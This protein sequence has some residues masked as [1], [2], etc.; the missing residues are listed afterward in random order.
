ML[1]SNWCRGDAETT[2]EVT[3]P[4]EGGSIDVLPPGRPSCMDRSI[5]AS[6][7]M[8]AFSSLPGAERNSARTIAVQYAPHQMAADDGAVWIVGQDRLVRLDPEGRLVWA[9]DLGHADGALIGG[10]HDVAIG[11]GAVWVTCACTSE[12]DPRFGA[13]SGGVVRIDPR[14]NRVTAVAIFTDQTPGQVLASNGAVWFTT[15]QGV[16]RVSVDD[17]KTE[18]TIRLATDY[19]AAGK[20]RIWAVTG[21]K[22]GPFLAKI[23]STSNKVVAK[24]QL[25]EATSGV[26]EAF[27]SVWVT[28]RKSGGLLKIDPYTGEAKNVELPTASA[29]AIAFGE[30]SIWVT[31]FAD[32]TLLRIDPKTERV[33]GTYDA[34]IDP[35]DVA[36]GGGA[37]WV[38]SYSDSTV[39]RIP[40]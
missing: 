4:D 10:G 36:V 22:G 1:W 37:L 33:V 14:M 20:G 29:D 39:T 23:D 7:S 25:P 13:T 32:H 28:A 26:V 17:L 5:P 12:P 18:A 24:W 8:G 35:A 11:E 15:G 6:L 27:G 19:L 38:L 9:F 3:L 31:S 21:G 40:A 16:T 30:G 2:I 34:G